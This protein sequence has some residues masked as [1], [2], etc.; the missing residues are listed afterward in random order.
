MDGDQIGLGHCVADD[1]KDDTEDTSFTLQV[2][3]VPFGADGHFDGHFFLFEVVFEVVLDHAQ[4]LRLRC[5]LD[6]VGVRIDD[7]K[8]EARK[9]IDQPDRKP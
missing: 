2:F 4:A 3:I 5:R 1:T 9:H 6:V 7:E 8:A